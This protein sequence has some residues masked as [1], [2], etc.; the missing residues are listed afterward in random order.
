L[1]EKSEYYE[2]NDNYDLFI[3]NVHKHPRHS[4]GQEKKRSHLSKD[5]YDKLDKSKYDHEEDN[6]LVPL[7]FG[8]YEYINIWGISQDGIMKKEYEDYLV[9]NKI[10]YKYGGW[11]SDK[12]M[13]TRLSDENINYIWSLF[14][15]LT[16][17]K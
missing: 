17:S 7:N 1:T 12:L 3:S 9:D 14:D 5:E 6:I 8:N 13:V 2:N 11:G 4:K 10:I 16:D 15:D